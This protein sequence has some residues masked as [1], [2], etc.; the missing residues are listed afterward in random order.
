M[1]IQLKNV[2]DGNPSLACVRADGSR[3]WSRVHPFFPI[4]DLTHYAVESVFGFERAFFGLVA[5]GWDIDTFAEPGVAATL[6]AEAIWAECMVG[7]FDLERGTNHQMS[8]KEFSEALSQSLGDHDVP[9]FRPVTDAE[10]AQVRALRHD[11]VGRWSALAPG[12]TLE[13]T[14]VSQPIS[15]LLNR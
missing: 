8:G 10:L 3:T 4:H 1:R 15:T 6:P 13:L 11:L 5:S 7:L 9:K 12:D 2:P 14:V